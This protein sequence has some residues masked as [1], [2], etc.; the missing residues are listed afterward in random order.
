MRIAGAVIIS[1]LDNIESVCDDL[2]QV[3]PDSCI[4]S[5]MGRKT[6]FFADE[7]AVTA[8][9][10]ARPMVPAS[11]L[12]SDVVATPATAGDDDAAMAVTTT[13]D[14]SIPGVSTDES[15]EDSDLG[16]LLLDAVLG[17]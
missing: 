6:A 8:T 14:E 3:V 9:A 13:V 12:S 17:L 5:L 16:E 11:V 1:P 2:L 15:D 7:T 10:T 4:S